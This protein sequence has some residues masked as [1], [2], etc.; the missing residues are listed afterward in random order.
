MRSNRVGGG[1]LFQTCMLCAETDI[2]ESFAHSGLGCEETWLAVGSTA[3]SNEK[4]IF[5][6]GPLV[7]ALLGSLG[8]PFSRNR[9]RQAL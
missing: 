8:R 4:R 6:S 9:G 3:G 7:D 5:E 2:V 1:G